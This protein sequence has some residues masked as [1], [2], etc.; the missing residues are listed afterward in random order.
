MGSISMTTEQV[1]EARRLAWLGENIT[2]IARAIGKNYGPVWN[3][4]RGVTWSSV[5]NPPPVPTFYRVVQFRACVNHH[6]GELYQGPPQGGFCQ[7]CYVYARRNNGELRKPNSLPIGRPPMDIGDMEKIYKRY[8]CGESIN[9]IAADLECSPETLRRRFR[10]GGYKMRDKTESR[11]VLTEPA[12]IQAR[13]MHYEDNVPIFEIA[14]YLERNYLTVFDA[15][16]GHTWRTAGG[17]LPR[18]QESDELQ[19]CQHCGV[20]CRHDELCR[21]CRRERDLVGGTSKSFV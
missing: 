13:V 18:D 9:T 19:P 8:L 17:P 15:V 20:L 12:V 1:Q 4:V 14:Q 3:A 2:D 6:C 7:S 21:F 16:K 10:R 11:R 5:H